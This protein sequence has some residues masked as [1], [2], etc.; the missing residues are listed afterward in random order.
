VTVGEYRG[1]R[2]LGEAHGHGAIPTLVSAVRG[3]RIVG[4]LDLAIAAEIALP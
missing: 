2:I 3:A 4:L 1:Q